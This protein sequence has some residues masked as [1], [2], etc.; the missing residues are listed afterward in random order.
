M[1]FFVSFYFLAEE[2]FKHTKNYSGSFC[3]VKW[4]KNYR[5]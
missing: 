5:L 1:N 4:T 3:P 2:L